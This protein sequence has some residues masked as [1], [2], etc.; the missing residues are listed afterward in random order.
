MIYVTPNAGVQLISGQYIFT[1]KT[2]HGR[3][4]K[5]K[6]MKKQNDRSDKD[7]LCI[8]VKIKEKLPGI[9][10]RGQQVRL[11]DPED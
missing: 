6:D 9:Q 5:Q 3:G 8:N 4:V 1:V 11:Y 2:H 10:I 7:L